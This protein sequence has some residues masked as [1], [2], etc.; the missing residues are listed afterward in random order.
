VAAGLVLV[1]AAGLVLVVA[2]GSGLVVAAGLGLVVAAGLGLVVAAGLVLVVAAS[3]SSPGSGTARW[4]GSFGDRIEI[5]HL[6]QIVHQIITL[7]VAL[8]TIKRPSKSAT[9]RK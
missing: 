6:S 2:A 5:F 7:W 4:F 9:A 3:D 1:V 8:T